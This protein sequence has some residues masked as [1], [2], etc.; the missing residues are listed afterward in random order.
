MITYEAIAEGRS[1]RV[2]ARKPLPEQVV[3]D[4]FAASYFDD[5]EDR[6][7]DAVLRSILMS[8][9]VVVATH[10]SLDPKDVIQAFF[11]HVG[12]EGPEKVFACAVVSKERLERML[13]EAAV[14]VEGHSLQ[15]APTRMI[16]NSSIRAAIQAWAER[17]YPD[18]RLPRFSL[19]PWRGAV[20]ERPSRALALL[21]SRR[22]VPV[23]GPLK[24]FADEFTSDF[25]PGPDLTDNSTQESAA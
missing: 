17:N 21:R 24:E 13:K 3:E 4:H 10:R 18:I 1:G 6:A 2:F 14:V 19:D 5:D 16:T 23:A 12:K 15:V 25:K 20:G 7:R 22:R 8:P 11:R 9:N